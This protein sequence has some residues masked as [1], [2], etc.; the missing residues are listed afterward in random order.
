[1]K[2]KSELL[3]YRLSWT[4]E[5]MT[6]P[7]W[8]NMDDSFE[9]WAY[10][11]GC[12]RQIQALEAQHLVESQPEDGLD[13]SR[14]YRLTELGRLAALGGR[15]PDV[16]WSRKWDEQWRMVMFD[17]PESARETRSLVRAALRKLHFGC[18]QKS[19]WISPCP[20]AKIAEEMK[21]LKVNASSLVLLEGRTCAGEAAKDLVGSAWDFKGINRAWDKLEQHLMTAPSKNSNPGKEALTDWSAEEHSLWKTCMALDPLLPKALHPSAYQGPSTWKLRKKVLAAQGKQLLATNDGA[22]GRS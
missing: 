4:F 7:T 13:G 6:R 10:R 2:A 19:V 14:I 11:S 8:R 5:I 18:L 17:V 3:L 9:S 16:A 12:L 21:R 20:L 1:M 15:D 22:N